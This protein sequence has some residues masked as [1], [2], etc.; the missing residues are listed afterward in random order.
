MDTLRSFR[1]TDPP[2]LAEV[3]RSQP[4]H[5]GRMQPITSNTLETVVFSK[6]YFQHA[7]LRIAE[8]AGKPVAFAHAGFRPTADGAGLDTTH[9]VIELV[10]ASAALADPA[11]EDAL[12]ADAEQYLR[13]HGATHI[14]AGACSDLGGFY[15]GLYGGS[16]T[17]GVLESDTHQRDLLLRNGYAPTTHV[18]VLQRDLARFRPPVSRAQL[19]LRRETIFE[20]QDLAPAANWWEACALASI[21]RTRFVLLDKGDRTVRASVSIWDIEPLAMSWG[22]RTAGLFGLWVD[23]DR[24][25]LGFATYL[26]GEALAV[27]R[28]RGFAMIEAQ[29]DRQNTPACELCARLGL[30]QV[31]SGASYRKQ[32]AG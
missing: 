8:R 18:A 1:N 7:G 26:L 6:P 16:Q 4:P 31:D 29:V 17:P 15:L 25:R 28:Q 23:P 24:L 5:R 14:E 2:H 11:L 19:K 13:S 9:G 20:V 30:T 32:P 10:M 27:V 3:W 12:L 22:L 21:E